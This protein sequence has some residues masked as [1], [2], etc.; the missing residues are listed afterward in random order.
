MSQALNIVQIKN[1]FHQVFNLKISKSLTA[2]RLRI[3]R[4]SVDKYIHLFN[5]ANLSWPLSTAISDQ[6]LLQLLITQNPK[7]IKPCRQDIDFK[8]V[9]EILSTVKGATILAIYEEWFTKLPVYE[10]AISYS[11][12]AH[13]YQNYKEKLRV[14]LRTTYKPGECIYVDYSGMTVPYIDSITGEVKQAQIFVGVLGY[15][16]FT[17]C[18]ATNSQSLEDWIMSHVRMFK[19]FD[20][21]SELVIHDNLKSAVTKAHRKELELNTSYLRMCEFFNIIPFPARPYH[22]K[23]KP[24]AEAAV[25]LVQRWILFKLRKRQFFS[26]AE[27]NQA[28]AGLL[29]YLNKKPFQ[30]IEGNR[31]SRYHEIEKHHLNKLPNQVYRYEYWGKVSVG[32]DYHIVIDSKAYS[33]PYQFKGK[34]LEYCKTAESIKFYY[35]RQLIA[36]HLVCEATQ[37]GSTKVEHMPKNHQA[38]H[39]YTP[40][41]IRLWSKGIGHE[42]QD[43]CEAALSYFSTPFQRYRFFSSFTKIVNNIN[44]DVLISTLCFQAKLKNTFEI[45]S[46]RLLLKNLTLIAQYQNSTDKTP[47]SYIQHQNLRGAEY[48]IDKNIDQESNNE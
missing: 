7:Q 32:L 48:F 40:E 43:F 38:V 46:M 25:L 5:Q 11:Q 41:F 27:I 14:S 15:S 34:L 13:R 10:A 3:S 44:D 17:Y 42:C 45:Q 35:Q 22:P 19:Y 12:F 8:E 16:S 20:G 47:E 24:K 29:D 4:D 1:I 37:V 28:I 26:I 39:Q 9:H 33:V 18:E 30:K 6:D 23:D 31:Y 21:T 2:K 36:S